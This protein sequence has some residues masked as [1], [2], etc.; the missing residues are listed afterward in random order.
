MNVEMAALYVVITRP[1]KIYLAPTSVPVFMDI[2]RGGVTEVKLINVKVIFHILLTWK[3]CVLER[4]SGAG[5]R[6]S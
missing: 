6:Y 1:A 2:K 5:E 4:G 3:V